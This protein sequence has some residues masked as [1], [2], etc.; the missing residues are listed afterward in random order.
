MIPSLFRHNPAYG[1]LWIA[2]CLSTA[3]DVLYNVAVVWF[4]VSSTGSAAAG[5]GIAIGVMIG[6]LTGGAVAGTRLD[7]WH[8]RHV[9]LAADAVRFGAAGAVGAAWALGHTPSAM[10]LYALAAGSSFC[11]AFFQPARSAAIPAIVP[12]EQLIGAGAAESFGS[13][14]VS[15]LSW[16]AS[17]ALVAWVGIACVLVID[18]A[19]FLASFLLVAWT[20]WPHRG[21][22][23]PEFAAQI[24]A[25]TRWVRRSRVTSVMLFIESV[26]AMFSGLV[27]ATLP[28][29]VVSLGGDAG[30]FGLQG[31]LSALAILGASLFIGR[32]L[33]A[34]VGRLYTVGIAV[35]A[36]GLLIMA[37]S[38]VPWLFLVGIAVTGLGI[39]AWTAAREVI[40]QTRVPPDLRGRVFAVL[41]TLINIS[42]LPTWAGGALLAD[43]V[44]PRAVLIA[45]P[46]GHALIL[47]VV[48]GAGI[49]GYRTDVPGVDRRSNGPSPQRVAEVES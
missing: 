2:Q 48:V 20:R 3:G 37:L 46:C 9:M 35:N 28:L 23:E 40:F 45:A 32:R 4:L 6:A 30:L 12:H 49:A 16:M 18:A 39:P 22:P 29:F 17:A 7:S 10:T 47:L 19:T 42:L 11:N 44:G 25:V 5:S 33:T 1:R 41:H 27:Y 26:H 13:G 24:G 14:L 31:G 21:R 38:R 8:P 15:G 34:K 43:R 36:V